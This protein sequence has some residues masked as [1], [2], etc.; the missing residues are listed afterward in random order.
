MQ[1][2]REKVESLIKELQLMGYYKFQIRNMIKEAANKS[3]Y[4]D[5]PDEQLQKVVVKLE[6]MVE[7]ARQCRK[8]PN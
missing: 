1:D 6:E 4:R 8:V 7:F 5:L 2:I 3:D